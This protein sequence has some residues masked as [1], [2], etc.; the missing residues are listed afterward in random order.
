LSKKKGVANRP[1]EGLVLDSCIAIAWCLPDEQ[2]AYSQSILDAL[3]TG[4][5]DVPYLWHLEV[6]NTLLVAERRKRCTQ[7]DTVQWMRFLAALPIVVD[8]ETSAHAFGDI[9]GIARLHQ[10]SA[11]DAAYLELA[12]RKRLPLAT[13]DDKLKVA[14]GAA[15]VPL[16]DTH[17]SKH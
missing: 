6:T 8:E 13:L 10:L 5:A 4:H 14:A 12:M 7:G 11:Y 16:S 9:A 15:G 3:A 1:P 2:D 17:R